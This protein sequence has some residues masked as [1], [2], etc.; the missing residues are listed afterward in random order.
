MREPLRYTSALSDSI[1][2]NEVVKALGS[3]S[4]FEILICGGFRLTL[5]CLRNRSKI[6]RQF[7]RP[8]RGL[9]FW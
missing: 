6:V 1:L 8:L 7:F 2:K 4:S 9:C 3:G 5:L